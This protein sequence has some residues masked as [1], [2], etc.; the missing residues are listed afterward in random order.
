MSSGPC[1]LA[2]RAVLRWILNAFGQTFRRSILPLNS[3]GYLVWPACRPCPFLFEMMMGG[4][5]TPEKARVID[6]RAEPA[7]PEALEL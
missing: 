2:R 1:R 6:Y 4:R 7:L 3:T 5:V